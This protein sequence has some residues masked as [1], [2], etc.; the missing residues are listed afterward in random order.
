MPSEISAVVRTVH[1]R[2]LAGGQCRNRRHLGCREP[3]MK[4]LRRLVFACFAAGCSTAIAD[5]AQPALYSFADV[6]RLTVNGVAPE[7][8]PN[9]AAPAAEPQV[10][11]AAVQGALAAEP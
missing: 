11:V 9:L 5:E 10:R 8:N 6:Y 4:I 7:I 1:R 2:G 3:A